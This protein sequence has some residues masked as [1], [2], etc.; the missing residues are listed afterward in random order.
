MVAQALRSY[1]ICTHLF[2]TAAGDL[3]YRVDHMAYKDHVCFAVVCRSYV[4]PEPMERVCL[5]QLELCGS[6]WLS[7]ALSG[8]LWLFL[9][10]SGSLWRSLALSGAL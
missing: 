10:L 5:G 3:C 8:S 1:V 2:R 6:V 4:G 9:V 7:L